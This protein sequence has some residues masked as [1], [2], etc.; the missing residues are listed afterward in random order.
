MDKIMLDT[1][2]M[3]YLLTIGSA[4]EPRS[5][6]V[7]TGIH[8][9]ESENSSEKSKGVWGYLTFFDRISERQRIILISAPPDFS[10][11]EILAKSDI[12]ENFQ[13]NFVTKKLWD[14]DVKSLFNP[15]DDIVERLNDTEEIQKFLQ[16]FYP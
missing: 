6:T 7:A 16:C 13:F 14:S 9:I 5:R 15:P 1:G 10:E 3:S 11:K 12:G 2:N 4:G 8:L